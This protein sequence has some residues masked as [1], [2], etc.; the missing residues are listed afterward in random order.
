MRASWCPRLTLRAFFLFESK[1]PTPVTEVPREG[2][3]ADDS[4]C[5]ERSRLIL[6]TLG[7]DVRI[8]RLGSFEW[9]KATHSCS[10]SRSEP[11]MELED[12]RRVLKTKEIWPAALKVNKGTLE[13]AERN[14]RQPERRSCRDST[15]LKQE[16]KSANSSVTNV[17]E[18]EQK[19]LSRCLRSRNSPGWRGVETSK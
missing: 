18:L 15:G 10:T 9:K 17:E 4:C 12:H 13:T 8:I 7:M 11:T 19:N 16:A 6:I 3:R 5:H 2:R 1:Q 14:W